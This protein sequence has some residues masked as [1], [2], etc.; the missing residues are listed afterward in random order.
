MSQI[1]E[2]TGGIYAQ[3][4]IE[5]RCKPLRFFPGGSLFLHRFLSLLHQK[6]VF[7]AGA[8]DESNTSRVLR[9]D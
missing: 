3:K 7:F 9:V 2:F 8:N 5:D 1:I 6:L 4:W